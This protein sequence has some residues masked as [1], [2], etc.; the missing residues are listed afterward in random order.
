MSFIDLKGLKD[1]KEPK[2]APEGRYPLTI[3][4]AKMHETENGQS[5]ATVI[6]VESGDPA[7]RYANVF[8]YVALPNGKDVD[9]DQTKLLMAKR[10]FAQFGI[11]ADE[12]VELEHFVGSRGQGNLAVEEYQGQQKNTLKLDRLA[13]EA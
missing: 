4:N 6:E 13:A 11:N 2:N 3:I 8:H 12:G 1:V 9:K 5:I 10:F 7:L